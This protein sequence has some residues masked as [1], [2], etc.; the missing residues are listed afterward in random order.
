MGRGFLPIRGCKV[1]LCTN[2]ASCTTYLEPTIAIFTKQK[3]FK[4]NAV[5]APEH[6]FFGALQDQVRAKTYYDKERRVNIYSL[7]G[8]NLVP[9]KAILKKIDVL[10][11][12][13][14]DIGTR[15]Y[16]FIWSALLLIEQAA[17][18]GKKI[19]ILDRPNPLNGGGRRR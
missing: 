5:F 15:Y 9:D 11:I 7:Y 1:G 8:K 13:L 12:D 18:L 19:L 2:I 17:K 14:Q 16:T 10:V 4:L 3:K 6:G